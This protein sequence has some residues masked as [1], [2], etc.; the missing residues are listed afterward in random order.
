MDNTITGR[1]NAK[2]GERRLTPFK[3][4]KSLVVSVEFD[5]LVAILGI[6]SSGNID[7]DRVINDEIHLTERVNLVG[8]SSK[9]LHGSAHSGKINNSWNASKILKQD[10]GWLEWDLERFLGR[11][12]PVQ[13]RLNISSYIKIRS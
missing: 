3:E 10:S 7:L 6:F 9:L 4:G 12:L 8:I 1:N 5:L 11:L 13:D 2:V